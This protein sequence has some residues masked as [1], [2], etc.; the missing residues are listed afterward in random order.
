[1]DLRKKINDLRKGLLTPSQN[2][3][4]FLAKIK[5]ENKK[6]NIFLEINEAAIEEARI[7]EKTG[8]KGPLYGL[9]IASKSNINVRG[10]KTTCASQT[11]KNYI[12]TYDADVIQKIKAAGGI[13]IGMTNCD[14][15][16]CGSSGE[17]SAFGPTE[18]PVVHGRIPGGSS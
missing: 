14:E 6:L 12:A 18:N 10:L 2:I 7:V 13:I 5:R 17:N 1:M 15:F 16:A 3:E 4:Q 9:A 8:K 11:L